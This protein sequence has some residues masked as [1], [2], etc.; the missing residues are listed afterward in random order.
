ML[1]LRD[2]RYRWDST[3][4][5]KP[6]PTN[7]PASPP[8]ISLHFSD[9]CN[10]S[11]SV[12]LLSSQLDISFCHRIHFLSLLKFLA[13]ER[14]AGRTIVRKISERRL[15]A[16]G[17]SCY[18]PAFTLSSFPTSGGPIPKNP[19]TP[20]FDAGS[21]CSRSRPA[22]VMSTQNGRSLAGSSL[23]LQRN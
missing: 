7:L 5:S 11:R 8:S 1:D 6:T 20:L 18:C 2:A 15:S 14:L 3:S 21:G 9:I 22:D 10:F 12:S 23:R 16:T 13:A 4:S 19:A 17:S